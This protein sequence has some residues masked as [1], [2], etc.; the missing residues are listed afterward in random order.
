MKGLWCAGAWLCVASLCA[1]GCG[2]GISTAKVSGKVTVAGAPMAGIQVS[3]VPTSGRGANGITDAEGKFTLNTVS[4][5]DGAVPGKHKVTFAKSAFDPSKGPPAAYNY[6]AKGGT[7][8]QGPPSM[9]GGPLPFNEKYTRGDTSG[10]EVEVV[11]G[12]NNEFTFDLEK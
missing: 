8:G 6:G 2:S 5:G 4:K 12:K 1:A 11:A 7:P 3:F 10:F 9:P